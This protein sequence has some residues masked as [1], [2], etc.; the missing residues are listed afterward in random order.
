MQQCYT[1]KKFDKCI[2][3]CKELFEEFDGQMS[4]YYE[5]WIER[6]EYMKTQDL[7]DDWNGVFI[8]TT[9]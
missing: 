4:K 9:K 7:P 8:A 3:L 6:C 1:E 5:M 2:K